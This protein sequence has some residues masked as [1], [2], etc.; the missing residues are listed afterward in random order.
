LPAS[1]SQVV[2]LS[3]GPDTA[4]Y[5]IRPT[6]RDFVPIKQELSEELQEELEALKKQ[7]QEAD[8]EVPTRW[9]FE[10]QTL[11]MQD[12]GG[13]QFKWILK[14]DKITLCIGRGKKTG[15]IGQL[16][17][18]SEYLWDCDGD[19]G[20]ALTKAYLFL[21]SLY[22]EHILLDQSTLDLAVDVL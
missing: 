18:N 13:S 2:A 7:A 4:T 16:R 22:G 1:S 17:L 14:N 6:D 3:F 19:L 9:I 5:M 11:F 10:D 20:L 8:E 21:C 12:K 15:I